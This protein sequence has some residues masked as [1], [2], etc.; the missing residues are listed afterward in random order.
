MPSNAPQTHS[1]PAPYSCTIVIS[2]I[3][4]ANMW[5]FCFIFS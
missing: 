3:S 2:F 4:E 1:N 5:F